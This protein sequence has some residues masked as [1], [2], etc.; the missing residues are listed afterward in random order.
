MF[1]LPKPPTHPAA[2]QVCI[3]A[4][5][6]RRTDVTQFE[7]QDERGYLFKNKNKTQENQPTYT[8]TA[9]VNGAMKEI[10]AWIATG[11]SGDKYLSI[12]FSDPQDRVPNPDGSFGPKNEEPKKEFDDEI[13][14]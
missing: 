11:R 6:V 2:G 1:F 8:G 5:Q 14:F 3:E 9:K 7:M 4:T 10:A 12:R 13:P